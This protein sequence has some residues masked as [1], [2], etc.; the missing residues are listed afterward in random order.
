MKKL[1]LIVTLLI[2][3][4][5]FS[6]SFPE[7]VR[8]SYSGRDTASVGDTI[9]R[10]VASNLNTLT[11]KYQNWFQ[12]VFATDDTITISTDT[13][14]SNAMIVYPDESLLTPKFNIRYFKNL[15][16]KVLGSG[17]ATVRYYL[18]GN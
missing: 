3:T 15:Y 10:K 13:L 11:G 16:W 14:Y 4:N 17:V 7:P 1:L 12:G 18:F 5:V 8:F 2:A 9:S 6:Q